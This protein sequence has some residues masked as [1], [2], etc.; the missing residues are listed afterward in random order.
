M[1]AL[2]ADIKGSA[3][4]MEGLDPEEARAIVDPALKL[5]IEAVSRYD[6]YIVLSTGDAF[7][8]SWARRSPTRT[9]RN[10]LFMR[11]SE[12]RMSFGATAASSSGRVAP[13]LRYASESTA[14]KS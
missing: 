4:L 11:R 5:M 2:F 9:I 14:A 1:T 12:C 10:E 6:R 13:R 8:R 3:E 7:S